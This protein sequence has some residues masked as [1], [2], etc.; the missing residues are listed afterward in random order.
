MFWAFRASNKSLF[1]AF[2]FVSSDYWQCVWELS[3]HDSVRVKP[4][5][6]PHLPIEKGA[7]DAI[8]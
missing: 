3:G 2:R 4:T 1:Q 8:R 5:K 7:L 6:G